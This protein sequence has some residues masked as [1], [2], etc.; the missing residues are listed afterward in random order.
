[1][2]IVLVKLGNIVFDDFEIPESLQFGGEQIGS[3]HQL[4]GG[5]RVVDLMGNSVSNIS[6]SG[7]FLG[8][9]AIQ[10]ARY[11]HQV[12]N[13]AQQQVFTYYDFRYNVY[14]KSFVC[15]LQASY[16]IPFSIE[17]GVIEDL[18]SPQNLLFPASFSSVIRDA[19]I[20]AL[21]IASFIQNPSLDSSLALLGAA[22][23]TIGDFSDASL[24]SIIEIVALAQ[25]VDDVANDIGIGL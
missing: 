22:I 11:V 6:W 23:N 20:Q 17:L 10:R 21:D 2:S 12:M 3:V 16:K 25:N 7:Y 18:T 5:K 8:I 9:D 15:N 1:M 24:S 13:Q 19:Y 4:I 14:I